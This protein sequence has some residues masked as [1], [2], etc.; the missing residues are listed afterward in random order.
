MARTDGYSKCSANLH[1]HAHEV[2]D[3]TVGVLGVPLD[4]LETSAF[5]HADHP[6]LNAATLSTM[7]AES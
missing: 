7:R 4:G 2:M 3:T 6:E 5:V 1:L